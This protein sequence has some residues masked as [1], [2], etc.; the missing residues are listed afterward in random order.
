MVGFTWLTWR[1]CGI[2]LLL[3]QEGPPLLHGQLRRTSFSG[4]ENSISSSSWSLLNFVFFRLWWWRWRSSSCSCSCSCSCSSSRYSSSSRE[5]L[6]E[7]IH[8]KILRCCSTQWRSCPPLAS[9]VIGW[10][11]EKSLLLLLLREILEGKLCH[12]WG[13]STLHHCSEEL[14]SL[15]LEEDSKFIRRW[16]EKNATS[17]CSF[18]KGTV[19]QMPNHSRPAEWER[20]KERK[21]EKKEE[22]ARNPQRHR[23]REREDL[24]N[25][26]LTLF[27]TTKWVARKT[28]AKEKKEH[29]KT[30]GVWWASNIMVAKM[31]RRRRHTHKQLGGRERGRSVT[32]EV[33]ENLLSLS[34]FVSADDDLKFLTFALKISSSVEDGT[35]F[36]S[37]LILVLQ[38]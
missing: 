30:G 4:D 29:S 8:K 18:Q 2:L 31:W 12:R 20:K 35:Q 7:P 13:Q 32:E 23:D 1:S 6:E 34:Q 5:V 33:L 14:W 9:L 3:L 19:V 26:V 38:Y 28:K 24:S 10:G 16:R 36:A 25:Q 17:Y 15:E 11:E 22:T 27:E 21:K 37:A